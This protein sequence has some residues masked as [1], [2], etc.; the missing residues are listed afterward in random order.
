MKLRNILSFIGSDM[1]L[2]E[3]YSNKAK[4]IIAPFC[5]EWA[6]RSRIRDT[7][8]GFYEKIVFMQVRMKS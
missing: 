2:T 1:V 8:V 4:R 5:E 7:C 3:R 6:F